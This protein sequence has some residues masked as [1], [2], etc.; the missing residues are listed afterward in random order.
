MFV[1]LKLLNIVDA[2]IEC[3][4]LMPESYE[5]AQFFKCDE[6]TGYEC[7][8]AGNSKLCGDTQNNY[9]YAPY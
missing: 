2:K 3:D 9:N 7:D 8:Y 6:S 5:C 4:I 1:D